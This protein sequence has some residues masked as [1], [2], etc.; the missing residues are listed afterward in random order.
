MRSRAPALTARLASRSSKSRRGR[1][2]PKSGKSGSIGQSSSRVVPPPTTRS[3]R[4]RIQSSPETSMP[5]RQHLLD[6]ARGQTVAAH[7]LPGEGGLLQQQHVDPG[8]GQVGGRRR[9]S[10]TRADDDHV[11]GVLRS[12]GTLAARHSCPSL[13]RPWSCDRRTRQRVHH[14]RSPP[15]GSRADWRHAHRA[16]ALVHEVVRGQ[17]RSGHKPGVAGVNRTSSGPWP[18]PATCS[19]IRDHRPGRR[20]AGRRHRRSGCARRRRASRPR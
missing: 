14:R 15:C 5:E 8:P 18:T 9:A 1:T 12:Y 17:C 2:R 20:G 7:L 10:R 13:G 16:C 11:G 4:L 6:A 3:P 19:F